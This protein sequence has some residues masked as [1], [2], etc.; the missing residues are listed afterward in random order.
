MGTREI[1]GLAGSGSDAS[2]DIHTDR[3]DE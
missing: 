3:Q 1:P 2:V